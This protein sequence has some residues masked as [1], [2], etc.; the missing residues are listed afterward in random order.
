M[1]YYK[2]V[3]YEIER[4]NYEGNHYKLIVKL[5]GYNKNKI[6]LFY[7]DG[8]FLVT[9]RKDSLKDIEKITQIKEPNVDLSSIKSN[10]EDGILE[11]KYKLLENEDAIE[12][13]IGDKIEN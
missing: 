12:V 7:I 10:M 1:F 8:N 6:R 11:I 2:K 4:I 5:P 13:P 9:T 3:E